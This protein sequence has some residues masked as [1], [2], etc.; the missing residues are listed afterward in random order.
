MS[1]IYRAMVTSDF[2]V[3]NLL[4][5]YSLIGDGNTQNTLYAYFG[6]SEAWADNESDPKFAP[7]YPDDTSEG[8]SDV[9]SRMLGAVKIQ[10]ELIRPVVPRKDW[11]DQRYADPYTFHIGDIVVTN[12]APYNTTEIG[13]GWMVY[14]CVDVPSDGMCSIQTI[15]DKEECLKV[16]GKWTPSIF[17][18]LPIGRSDGVNMQDGY[19]WEYLYTIPT[20][21][22]I[23][24]CSNEYI[25]VPTPDELKT[26]PDVWG[27]QH[28]ITW[29]P[30]DYNLIGRIK[31]NTLRFRSYF[32]SYNFPASSKIGNTG[33]R[34]MG[35][36]NNPLL[37][38]NTPADPDVKATALSY[39]PSQLERHSGN[40][41]YMDNRQ[42]VIR[43]R[44]QTEE[45]NVVF[46]F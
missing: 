5:F 8:Y 35:I 13:S 11:G 16:G 34:Q 9:W 2:R 38:K 7:P 26:S 29:Y 12:S 25:V 19:I 1:V 27:Y 6:R 18:I 31:C 23:N 30:N 40:I 45:F 3:A 32:D 36:I 22:A 28:V 20:D 17:S 41:I 43:S 37:V 39:D 21:V 46:S 42:P 4:N 33:F 24:D 14:R 44:D 10:K 15:K